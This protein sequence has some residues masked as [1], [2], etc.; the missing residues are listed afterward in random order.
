MVPTVLPTATDAAETNS[1]LVKWGKEELASGSPA[2]P[3]AARYVHLRGQNPAP[4]F[5]RAYRRFAIQSVAA[6][7]AIQSGTGAQRLAIRVA[8]GGLRL[9]RP[10]DQPLRLLLRR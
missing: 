5:A 8:V 10:G 4:C 6:R 7:P 2:G 1:N 3:P 9:M